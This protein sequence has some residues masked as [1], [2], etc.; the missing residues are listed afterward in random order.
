MHVPEEADGNQRPLQPPRHERDYWTRIINGIPTIVCGVTPDGTT[1]FI[2]PAGEQVTGYAFD[3]IVGRN[4][5]QIL[6][7]GDEYGQVER[8]LQ[9]SVDGSVHDYEMV[10]TSKQGRKRVISWTSINQHDETGKLVEIV[11]FGSDV[12]ERKQAEEK[13]REDRRFLKQLLDLQ[14]RERRLVAYEIHD[15]LAQQLTGGIMQVQAVRQLKDRI[16]HRSRKVLR[17]WVAI[18]RRRIGRGKKVDCGPPAD[19]SG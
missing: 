7:P 12:T 18:A 3:E 11:G 9:D 6:Y 14:E 16:L 10:L 13:L 1:T 5:W 2:N 4:W 17:G 19:D 15:G 8:L